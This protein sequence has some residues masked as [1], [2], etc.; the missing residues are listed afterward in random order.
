MILAVE[1]FQRKY[2]LHFQLEF[3]LDVVGQEKLNKL[4]KLGDAIAISK[5]ETITRMHLKRWIN[6]WS[7]KELTKMIMV[8]TTMAV[9]FMSLMQIEFSWSDYWKK[10]AWQCCWGGEVRREQHGDYFSLIASQAKSANQQNCSAETQNRWMEVL[11][12]GF[13]IR[14]SF[15]TLPF[16]SSRPALTFFR[17]SRPVESEKFSIF[18]CKICRA[19]QRIMM[20][21]GYSCH[22]YK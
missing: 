14:F 2:T 10:R 12:L 1:A 4:A 18:K 8:S 7:H 15:S 20:S 11:L 19:E 6:I 5:S 22:T 9:I 17:S 13:S 21:Q 16:R 3:L